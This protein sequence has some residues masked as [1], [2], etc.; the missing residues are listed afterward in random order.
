MPGI[1]ILVIHKECVLKHFQDSLQTHYSPAAASKLLNDILTMLDPL[2]QQSANK[3]VKDWLAKFSALVGKVMT[4]RLYTVMSDETNL[5]YQQGFL[6][7]NKGMQ[8]QDLIGS[9]VGYIVTQA[10]DVGHDVHKAL[11]AIGKRPAPTLSKMI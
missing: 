4:V 8:A 3:T 10:K 11:V 9:L 6:R 5:F 1:L 2:W 7:N